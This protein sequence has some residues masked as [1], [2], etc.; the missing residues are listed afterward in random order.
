M[1]NAIYNEYRNTLPVTTLQGVL[2]DEGA[3]WKKEKNTSILVLIDD[4]EYLT[5]DFST[6]IFKQ[7]N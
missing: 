5:A 3:L 6:E 7:I 2:I 1:N 4:D